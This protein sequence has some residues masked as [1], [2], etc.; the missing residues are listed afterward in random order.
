LNIELYPLIE[1][2][3]SVG[4]QQDQA[5]LSQTLEGLTSMA[6]GLQDLLNTMGAQVANLEASLGQ[7]NQN[8]ENN[9]Y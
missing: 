1:K 5:N 4:V 9:R 2:F 8:V 6:T 3:F 7:T